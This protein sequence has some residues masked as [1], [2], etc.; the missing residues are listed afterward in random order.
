LIAVPSRGEQWVKGRRAGDR[1]DDDRQRREPDL[2]AERLERRA[3]DGP[4]RGYLGDRGLPLE[5]RRN[6]ASRR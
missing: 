3:I 6:D 2:G 5:V 4:E 1:G